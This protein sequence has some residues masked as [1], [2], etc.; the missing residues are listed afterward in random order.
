MT[1]LNSLS[2]NDKQYDTDTS[3]ARNYNKT[4]QQVHHLPV[5]VGLTL[6]PP[7]PSSLARLVSSQV[8]RL[9]I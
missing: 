7:S 2:P 5:P 3:A 1:V 6:P 8:M 9:L 4:S